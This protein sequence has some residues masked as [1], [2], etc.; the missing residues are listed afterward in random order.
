MALIDNIAGEK[1]KIR[2]GI[3]PIELSNRRSEHC[4][5]IDDVL[6]ERALSPKM[7]VRYLRDP[8]SDL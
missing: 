3:K 4:V 5:G 8:H 2:R 6:V 1:N 7:G